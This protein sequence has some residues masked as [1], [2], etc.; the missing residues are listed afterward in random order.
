VVD[1][2]ESELRPATGFAFDQATGDAM[3]EGLDR[4]LRTYRGSS[5]AWRALQANGMSSDFGWE[6]AAKDYLDAYRRPAAARPR[7]AHD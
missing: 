2:D 5:T 7:H 4:C 1:L 6:R 3:D